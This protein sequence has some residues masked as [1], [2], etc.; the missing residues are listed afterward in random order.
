MKGEV[1]SFFSFYSEAFGFFFLYKKTE[2]MDEYDREYEPAFRE[3]AKR[4]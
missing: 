2:R 4:R 3:G 1:G